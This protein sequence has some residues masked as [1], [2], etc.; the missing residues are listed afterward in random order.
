MYH[1]KESQMLPHVRDRG[2]RT[3]NSGHDLVGG[4]SPIEGD[5]HALITRLYAHRPSGGEIS[6]SD[7]GWKASLDQSQICRRVRKLELHGRH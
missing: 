5:A 1:G 2:S 7:E 3:P 4:G 6:L